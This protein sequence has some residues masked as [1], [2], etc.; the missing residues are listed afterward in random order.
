MIVNGK[1]RAII[2]H[3]RATEDLEI[4]QISEKNLKIRDTALFLV[5]EK[6]ETSGTHEHN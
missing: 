3:L 4:F 6:S 5:A 1:E 2:M